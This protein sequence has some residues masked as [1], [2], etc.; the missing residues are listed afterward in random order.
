MSRCLARRLRAFEFLP[1]QHA[2]EFGRRS[3]RENPEERE[4]WPIL[5]H[6]LAVH[7]R[8]VANDLTGGIEHRN[9]DVAVSIEFL[10]QR[11]DVA[12]A[13]GR[14]DDFLA[15]YD[16]AAGGSRKVL[17]EVVRELAVRIISE[18]VRPSRWVTHA[19]TDKVIAGA[20]NRRQTS[21]QCLIKVCT[22]DR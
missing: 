12:H 13:A 21:H 22:G 11:P 10:F 2:F 19:V 1:Q 16:G 15:I 7:A 3:N 14:I 18:C 6:R 4:V 9:S 20:K 8:E 17:F 5:A